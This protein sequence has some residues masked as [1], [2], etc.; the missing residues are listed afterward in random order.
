MKETAIVKCTQCA[1]LM[2]TVKGQ[3]TKICP[4][5]GAQVNLTRA[6]KVASASNAFEASEMLRKLKS[7]QGFNRKQT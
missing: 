6:Q 2:M 3:K 7:E 5:C 4:Y 1:G